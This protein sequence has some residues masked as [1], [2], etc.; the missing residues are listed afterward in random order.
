MVRV[1]EVAILNCD[2]SNRNWRY[3]WRYFRKDLDRSTLS[4]YTTPY[5][6]VGILKVVEANRLFTINFSFHVLR[7]LN[8]KSRIIVLENLSYGTF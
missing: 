4:L 5:F 2:T 3:N 8:I 1:S 6:I 7:A